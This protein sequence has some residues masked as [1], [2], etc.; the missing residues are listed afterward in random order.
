LYLLDVGALA[1]N[2]TSVFSTSLRLVPLFVRMPLGS[3]FLR[4]RFVRGMRQN[5][6]WDGWIDSV[7]QRVYTQPFLEHPRQVVAL[8]RR[9]NEAREPEPV[10]DVVLRI[11]VP[12]TLLLGTVPH[13]S[14]P[15]RVE[16]ERLGPIASLVCAYRLRGVGHFPHEEVPANVAD[17][18]VPRPPPHM[19][20]GRCSMLPE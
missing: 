17:L 12:V 6:G 2:R 4:G 11:R 10:E 7:T 20:S 8:A 15:D 14:A 1:Q 13:P 18:I 9:M 19:H 5:A 16:L 3:Q